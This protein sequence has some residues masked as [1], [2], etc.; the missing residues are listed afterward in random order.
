MDLLKL[1]IEGAEHEVLS[2]LG[3]LEWLPATLCVEFDQV[4]PLRQLLRT[5]RGLR[6]LGYKA[7]K[8]ERLNVLFVLDLRTKFDTRLVSR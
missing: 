2:S 7:S 8:A 3:E 4:R 1:D 5:W 6:R